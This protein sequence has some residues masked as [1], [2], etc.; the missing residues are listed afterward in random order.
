M[1]RI[2]TCK[3]I[4]RPIIQVQFNYIFGVFLGMCAI[5]YIDKI[6]K[7]YLFWELDEI[8]K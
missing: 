2:Y 8:S 4:V 6:R 7:V 5:D 3:N 1:I